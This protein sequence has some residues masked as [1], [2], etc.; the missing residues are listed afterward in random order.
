[1]KAQASRASIV[2]LSNTVNA[3]DCPISQG[4]FLKLTIYAQGQIEK[5]VFEMQYS[6]GKDASRKKSYLFE[7]RAYELSKLFIKT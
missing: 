7:Y 4:Y 1:V 3:I 2:L 5:H 6:I